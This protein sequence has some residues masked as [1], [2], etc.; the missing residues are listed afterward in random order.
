MKIL[1]LASLLALSAATG[2]TAID[3]AADCSG[4]CGKYKDCLGGSS[5]DASACATRCRD[6]AANSDD[7]DRRVDTCQACTDGNSCAGSV[8]TCAGNCAGIPF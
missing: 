3:R 5:Y 4:I 8:F 1:L 7:N 2:C 6:Y